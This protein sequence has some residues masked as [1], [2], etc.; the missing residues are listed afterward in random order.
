MSAH[1]QTPPGASSVTAADELLQRLGYIPYRRPLHRWRDGAYGDQTYV[2]GVAAFNRD[3]RIAEDHFTYRTA[4]KLN[5]I[6]DQHWGSVRQLGLSLTTSLG[7]LAEL[8]GEIDP[9]LGSGLKNDDLIGIWDRW[10]ISRGITHCAVE[11]KI[12]V[13]ADEVVSHRRRLRLGLSA[14][15]TKPKEEES[16]SAATDPTPTPS[17]PGRSFVDVTKNAVAAGLQI[18]IGARALKLAMQATSKLLVKAGVPKETL[19]LPLVKTL[20]LVGSPTILRLGA[21]KIPGLSHP[22]VLAVLELAQTSAYAKVTDDIVGLLLK[23]AGP[24][25]KGLQS[26]GES[27]ALDDGSGDVP[28]KVG[29]VTQVDPIDVEETTAEGA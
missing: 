9:T 17:L 3:Y 20:L 25:L 27:L 10:T 6:A 19:Q 15:A 21:G 1:G 24:L 4:A 18:G 28:A 13:L 14:T 2:Q 22:K 5:E 11:D 16:M 29:T 7:K 8:I 23:Q 26:L 12:A